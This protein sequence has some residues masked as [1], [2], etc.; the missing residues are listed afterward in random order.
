MTVSAGAR[1][2]MAAGIVSMLLAGTTGGGAA[3]EP[4]LPSYGDGSCGV[5]SSA[6]R[7]PF[8]G[9]HANGEVPDERVGCHRD[10][11]ASPGHSAVHPP[12]PRTIPSPPSLPDRTRDGIEL[13]RLIEM[14]QRRA[15]TA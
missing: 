10:G 8:L 11:V 5:P 1:R 3:C 9:D 12:L 14:A 6:G 4:R 13:N 7:A 2:R 15:N